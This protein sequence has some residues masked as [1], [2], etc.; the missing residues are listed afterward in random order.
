[1]KQPGESETERRPGIDSED[2]ARGTTRV[3]VF[4][5]DKEITGPAP[6]TLSTEAVP[7]RVCTHIP[8]PMKMEARPRTPRKAHRSRPGV[9]ALE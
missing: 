8:A 2:H 4:Y 3:V 5:E 9:D 6:V 1:M 7:G